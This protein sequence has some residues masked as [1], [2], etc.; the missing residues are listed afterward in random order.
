MYCSGK[1]LLSCRQEFDSFLIKKMRRECKGGYSYQRAVGGALC[2]V[3]SFPPTYNGQ[4]PTWSFDWCLNRHATFVTHSLRKPAKSQ[5]RR[6][7]I[8]SAV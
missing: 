4:V 6:E 5:G 2:M 3:T 8:I 7:G 1:L